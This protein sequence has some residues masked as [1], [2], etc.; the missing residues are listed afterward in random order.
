VEGSDIYGILKRIGATHL[1]HANS[2]I[3]S[4]TFL[5]QGGLLGRGFVEDHGLKTISTTLG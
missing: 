2:V 4:C 3:T 5:E 1:H